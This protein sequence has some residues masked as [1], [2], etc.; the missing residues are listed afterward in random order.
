MAGCAVADRVSAIG[1][2]R[3]LV[4]SHQPA[5]DHRRE[6]AAGQPAVGPTAGPRCA[7]VP[8]DARARGPSRNSLRSLH[9]LRSDRRDKHVDEARCARGR[10]RCA[11]RRRT[12][13]AVRPPHIGSATGVAPSRGRAGRTGGV[14]P[15]VTQRCVRAGGSAPWRRREAQGSWPRAQ[16]AS[17]TCLSHLSERS[18]RSE[19]SELCDGPRD[20]ASQG[21]RRAAT[22]AGSGRCRLP[23]RAVAAPLP[24]RRGE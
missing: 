12:R 15:P 21:S 16:R 7:R 23:V 3:A 1:A 13:A 10:D 18:E 17:S 24:G 22:T 6:A 9:S 19:R 20:R 11:S 14:L 8:C 2:V 5:P 4:G